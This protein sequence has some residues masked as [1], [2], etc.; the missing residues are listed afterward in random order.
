MPCNQRASNRNE[1]GE[2]VPPIPPSPQLPPAPKNTLG[3]N[4]HHHAGG[5]PALPA[6]AGC[7]LILNGTSP[8]GAID[9]GCA[10]TTYETPSSD[11]YDGG[12]GAVVR[13]RATSPSSSLPLLLLADG[14]ALPSRDSRP[15]STVSEAAA[16]LRIQ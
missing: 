6:S 14:P 13:G 16:S 7:M 10:S 3:N 4:P 1:N 8:V 9:L 15:S 5:S 12:R 2:T 11:A